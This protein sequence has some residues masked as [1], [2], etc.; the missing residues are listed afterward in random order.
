MKK[1][2]SIKKLETS[3]LKKT[4]LGTVLGGGV[5]DCTC[6]T[7]SVCHVDGVDEGEGAEN[8]I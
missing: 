3:K 5:F 4:Q 1:F 6:G 8:Q 7:R 2:K